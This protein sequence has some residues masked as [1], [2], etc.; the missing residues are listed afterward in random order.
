[1][2]DEETTRS[3]SW[4]YQCLKAAALLLAIL[5]AGAA[6]FILGSG[7]E[8]PMAAP[9]ENIAAMIHIARTWRA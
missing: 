1:M 2:N 9:Q 7:C 3:S 5:A 8:V 4:K 6:G